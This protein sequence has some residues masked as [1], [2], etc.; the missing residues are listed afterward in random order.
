MKI[1]YFTQSPEMSPGECCGQNMAELL[2]DLKYSKNCFAH[3]QPYS[4]SVE[5]L[6]TGLNEEVLS[7][8]TV[9]MCNDESVYKF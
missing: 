6:F 3:Y 2:Q 8:L 1:E 7:S 9:L 5:M 4:G